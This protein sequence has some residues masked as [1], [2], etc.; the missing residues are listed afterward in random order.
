MEK[1]SIRVQSETRYVIEVNDAGET[2]VFDL[3]DTSL[4]SRMFKMFEQI[5]TL[6]A[7]HEAKAK[8]IDQTPDAPYVLPFVLPEGQADQSTPVTQHM[9]E[10]SKIID[11]F[12]AGA[13]IAMDTFLGAGACQKIFGGANYFDMFS[14]L[15]AQLEPH[16]KKMGLDP[17]GLKKRVVD[18]HLPNREARRAMK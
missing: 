10:V 17:S 6:T 9:V 14:D 4:G 13:R 12:Y 18:K 15:L 7:E 11:E 2:I 16:F 3:A 1:N 5:D 8:D